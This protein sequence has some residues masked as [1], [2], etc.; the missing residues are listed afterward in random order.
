M[1]P[2]EAGGEPRPL[3]ALD[4]VDYSLQTKRC[5]PQVQADCFDVHDEMSCMAAVKF[6]EAELFGPILKSGLNPYD[7]SKKCEGEFT[8]T[9]CYPESKYVH[10]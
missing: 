8:D 7:L 10:R 9:L 1:R 4:S 3:A 5:F 2:H 6:C